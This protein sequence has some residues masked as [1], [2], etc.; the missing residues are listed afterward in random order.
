MEGALRLFPPIEIR[1]F[2]F[3]IANPFIPAVLFPGITFTLLYAWPFLERFLTGDGAPHELLDRPRDHPMRT[4]LGVGTLTF[5]GVLM[6]AGANDVIARRL[7][8]PVDD[9][10]AALAV[11]LFALPV[12]A[13][14]ITRAV[15]R[16]LTSGEAGHGRASSHE[17]PVDETRPAHSDAH[18]PT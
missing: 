2:G 6:L 15:A 17:L 7:G 1:A 14:V 11:A 4:A 3:M 5:Y 9:V 18:R 10:S 13:M 16:S 12:V 8:F